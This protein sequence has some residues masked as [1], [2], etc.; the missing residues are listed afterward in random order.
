MVNC[1]DRK[2]NR[3]FAA[4]GD[5]TRRAI[6]MRLDR[7]ESVSVSAI[8]KPLAI[9][10]PTLLKHLSVLG[11]AGLVTRSKRGRTVEISLSAAPLHEASGWLRRY[12]QT[13]SIGLSHVCAEVEAEGAAAGKSEG[14]DR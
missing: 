1:L 5:P 4:L 7:K 10:L 6:I 2:L 14:A 9:K 13:F 11:D 8:A 3:V 12:E